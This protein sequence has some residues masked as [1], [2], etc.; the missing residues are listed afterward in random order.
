MNEKGIADRILKSYTAECTDS[1]D[2]TV[3]SA[4]PSCPACARKHLGQAIVLLQE[5]V[6][7]YP[8]HRW[9]AMGHIAEAEAEIQG[10]SPEIADALRNIRKK[11]EVE[12]D[13][14]PSLIAAITKITELASASVVASK[15]SNRR[16]R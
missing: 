3:A 1:C 11:M 8:E 12:P 2:T 6:Q 4:R 14:V 5:S 16:V 15:S 10:Y 13:F 7:G 9:I